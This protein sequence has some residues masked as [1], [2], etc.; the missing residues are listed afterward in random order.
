MQQSVFASDNVRRVP[1]PNT[2]HFVTFRQLV[3][4]EIHKAARIASRKSME[5]LRESGVLTAAEIL[6]EVGSVTTEQ[7]QT[8]Q[9]AFDPFAAYDRVTV[10]ASAVTEWTFEKPLAEDT[11]RFMNEET[12]AFLA[13][14]ILAWSMPALVQ[15]VAEQEESQKNASGPSIAA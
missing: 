7:I 11:I 2:E 13:R 1:V 12:Q 3:P 4:D 6:K 15:T 14:E 5:Q 9:R 8:V 10:I